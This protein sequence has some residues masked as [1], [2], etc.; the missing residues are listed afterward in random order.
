MEY[1]QLLLLTGYSNACSGVRSMCEHFRIH[2]CVRVCVRVRVRV[3][4]C[5]W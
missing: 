5:V 4:V 1:S 2:V 3:R